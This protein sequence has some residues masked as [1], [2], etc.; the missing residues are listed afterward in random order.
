MVQMR[1]SPGKALLCCVY[2]LF[3]KLIFLLCVE[4]DGG[5]IYLHMIH[6]FMCC[7]KCL[8]R[9]LLGYSC[10]STSKF[11]YLWP[12]GPTK[13]MTDV[14]HYP[15]SECWDGYEKYIFT[16]WKANQSQIYL[17]FQAKFSSC[18]VFSHL[19]L[20]EHFYRHW[21]QQSSVIF[22]FF[23]FGI[24]TLWAPEPYIQWCLTIGI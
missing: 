22:Y 3:C 14:H 9:D 13:S 12:P 16:L 19:E 6:E 21:C 11:D 4:V 2:W 7:G 15:H 10:L 24:A 5:I 23:M 17:K 20:H 1:E 8:H 18:M